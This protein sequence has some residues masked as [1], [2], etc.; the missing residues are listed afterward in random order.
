MAVKKE[1]NLTTNAT[2]STNNL[3][4]SSPMEKSLQL[5]YTKILP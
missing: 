3:K 2:N 5:S 4:A 1:K